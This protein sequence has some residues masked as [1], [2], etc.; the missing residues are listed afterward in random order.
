MLKVKTYLDRSKI[1]G[2]GLFAAESIGAAK[3]VWAF[4]PK[5]D[6]S[7][8]LDEWLHMAEEISEPSFQQLQHLA[9]KEG[10]KIYTCLDNAQF[11][12][13]SPT[14]SNIMNLTTT[15]TMVTTRDIFAGEELLCNYFEFCDRDDWGLQHIGCSARI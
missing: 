12:N 4:H 6:L 9:Y 5:V 11:M 13:H 10:G 14:A 8:E 15:N 3:E 2:I 7:F 1:H